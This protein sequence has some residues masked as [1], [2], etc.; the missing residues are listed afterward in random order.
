MKYKWLLLLVVPS[1]LSAQQDKR[2][3][4]SVILPDNPTREQVIRCAT[5][6]RPSYRQLDYQKREML[7]FIHIGMNTFTG[8]EWGTG[9]ESPSIF[10]PSRLNAD[11]WV[12]TFKEAGLTGVILVTK[13]HDGFCVW[14]SKYTDHTVAHSPWRNG[15]GDLVKEVADACRKYDMKLCLYLS[16]WDMHEPTYGTDAYNDHYIHQLEELLT[17]YGPVYLLWFDGAGT[18]DAVS[19]KKMPFDWNRIFRRA[20]ELQPDV[21]LSGNAPDIRW[22]GNEKGKGRETEWC[23]QGIN[24]LDQFFGSLNGYSYK[25]PNLG[26]IE[27]LMTKKRLVWYPSRSGMPLRNGWF[28]NSKDDNTTK[29]MSYL[30][31]SYFSSVGR[32]SNL[33]P[34][35]SPDSTGRFPVKDAQRMIAFGQM[36]QRMKSVDY[37]KGAQA[38]PLGGWTSDSPSAVITDDSPFTS[39]HTADSVTSASAEIRLVKPATVNVIKLQ[40]NVRDFGQ[41]V[42]S[43]AIEAYLLGEWKEI[44]RGTTIGF[45]RMVHLTEPVHTDAFRVR[46]LNSRISIS[47]GNLSLYYIDS[48]KDVV[49]STAR[50]FAIDR[51][52]VRSLSIQNI[53]GDNQSTLFDGNNQSVWKGKIISLPASFVFTFN[54]PTQVG[55]LSYLPSAESESFI[56]RYSIYLSNDGKHWE[57]VSEGRFGNIQNNPIEQQIYFKTKTTKFVKLEV[58]SVTTE[59]KNV[60]ISELGLY[61]Q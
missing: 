39:W 31:D 17:N 33:L 12:R 11:D 48:V 19:G 9:K 44:A 53:E 37:A 3:G 41:R 50:Q 46:F 1:L 6:V 45:R 49:E 56:E 5:E 2:E 23:V 60:D 38:I 40:E 61:A 13:H 51:Q 10:N 58:Q 36:I 42:E 4:I 8:A 26:S 59:R 27:D 35:L 30:I 22:V 18:D 24:S 28:Y 7:G 15:K 52:S 32:N 29:S 43:F 20:R 34:N 55:G 21:L 47:F 14:P 54:K 16:P 57:S 25:T